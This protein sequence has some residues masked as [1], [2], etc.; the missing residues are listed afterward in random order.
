[1]SK[2]R[3]LIIELSLLNTALVERSKHLLLL[4]WQKV[5]CRVLCNVELVIDVII[6]IICGRINIPIFFVVVVVAVTNGF[7]PVFVHPANLQ[8]F[9]NW[10]LYLTYWDIFFLF[11][12]SCRGKSRLVHISYWSPESKSVLLGPGIEL[13]ITMSEN[14]RTNT[15]INLVIFPFYPSVNGDKLQAISLLHS[16]N[17]EKNP[18]LNPS[19]R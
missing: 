8:G 2:V 12:S 11:P 7:L 17:F 19:S 6:Y 5:T 14:W 1:M 9:S 4:L 10:T 13:T 15:L 16:G 3:T 18:L